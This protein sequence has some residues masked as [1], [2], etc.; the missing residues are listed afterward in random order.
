MHTEG[1]ER[2]KPA[3]PSPPKSESEPA[4]PSR[5]RDGLV[6][7]EI[8][9][10][11]LKDLSHWQAYLARALVTKPNDTSWRNILMA[12]KERF[13]SDAAR[14]ALEKRILEKVRHNYRKILSMQ[15]TRIAENG[16]GQHN[17]WQEDPPTASTST[18]GRHSGRPQGRASFCSSAYTR[19]DNVCLRQCL[20]VCRH[21]LSV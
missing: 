19:C 1:M 15:V 4:A 12:D 18:S 8:P 16:V 20:S 3:N 17:G 10:D 7:V 2:T 5:P 14:Y 9:E 21:C 6:T 11:V 13:R